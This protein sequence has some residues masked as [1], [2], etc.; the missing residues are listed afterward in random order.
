[1]IIAILN[2]LSADPIQ[3]LNRVEDPYRRWV[4]V[5]AHL[6]LAIL[7]WNWRRA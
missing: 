2:A 1:M 4:R 6:K 3:V 5:V 7:P